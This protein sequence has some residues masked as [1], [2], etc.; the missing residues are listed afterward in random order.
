MG[1]HQISNFQNATLTIFISKTTGRVPVLV[2]MFSFYTKEVFP[3]TQQDASSLAF[4]FETDVIFTWICVIPTSIQNFNNAKEGRLMLLR[5][6][7]EL[8]ARR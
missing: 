7:Q 2:I 4:E 1:S 5:K 3:A 8:E 6:K